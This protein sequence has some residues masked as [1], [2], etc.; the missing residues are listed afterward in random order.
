MSMNLSIS[1]NVAPTVLQ[2]VKGARAERRMAGYFC[3]LRSDSY[4]YVRSC[5]PL[6]RMPKSPDPSDGAMSK[7]TWERNMQTWRHELKR[8]RKQYERSDK[9]AVTPAKAPPPSPSA[10]PPPAS[11]ACHDIHR[12]ANIATVPLRR[13]NFFLNSLRPSSHR[14]WVSCLASHYNRNKDK[15]RGGVVHRS[16]NAN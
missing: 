8:L 10:R 15:I 13:Y 5:T 16:H 11:P 6:D 9:I 4:T 7:R 12:S 14:F 2:E 1:D 3:I